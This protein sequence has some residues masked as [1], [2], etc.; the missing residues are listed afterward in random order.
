M[1]RVLVALGTMALVGASGGL[2]ACSG[3]LGI[4]EATLEAEDSGA[5]TDAGAGDGLQ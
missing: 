2:F 3:L 5:A 1:R 4:G